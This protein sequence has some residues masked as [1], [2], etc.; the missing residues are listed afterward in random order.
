M[1]ENSL[2]MNVFVDRKINIRG[3]TDWSQI[4]TERCGPER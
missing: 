1:Y 4:K 3:I 2:Y